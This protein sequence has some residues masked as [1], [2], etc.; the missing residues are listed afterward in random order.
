MLEQPRDSRVDSRTGVHAELGVDAHVEPPPATDGHAILNLW[1]CALSQPAGMR[2]DAMLRVAFGETPNPRETRTLGERNTMLLALHSRLFGRT[3][4]LVSHCPACGAA[5]EFTGDCD[6]LVDGLRPLE[7]VT[8]PLRL[9]ERGYVVDF[10]LPVRADIELVARAVDVDDDEAF[11]RHV[12]RRCVL[13]CSSETGVVPVDALPESVV[14]ALSR[15]M[16]LL[17]PGASVSFALE[18]PDCTSQWQAPLDVGDVL[19]QKTRA[20]A[21]RLLLDVDALASAYGW[22]EAEVLSLNPVRRAAYLQL[23]TS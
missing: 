5:A 10:R 1:E 7:G 20:E 16:E 9:E 22:T 2:A 21:E 3:I 13:A 23:V 8:L 6:A 4:D 12:L 19:W 11:A 18:C 17:D 14:D 15:R